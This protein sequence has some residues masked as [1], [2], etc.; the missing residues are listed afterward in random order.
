MR[1]WLREPLNNAKEIN[2]RLDGV[3]ELYN[4]LIIRNNIKQNLKQIYDF[5]RLAGRIACGNANGKDLIALRNS[6]AVLPEIKSD[7]GVLHSEIMQSIDSRICDLS[8]V[9]NIIDRAIC[10]EPPFTVKEGS[11]ITVI[12]RNWTA[13]SFPLKMRRHGSRRW[14]EKS[15]NAQESKI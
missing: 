12:R 9:Y 1:Q 2:L 11:L 15:A 7:L 3:E 4:E 13:L 6:I 14:K 5:E 8:A 10:D